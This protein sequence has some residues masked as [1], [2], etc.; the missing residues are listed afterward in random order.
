MIRLII[1][2]LLIFLVITSFVLFNPFKKAAPAGLQVA[3]NN[4]PSSIFLNDQLLNKTPLIE[5]TLKPGRYTI[6]I[7]PDDEMYVP[8]ETSIE[9]RSGALTV[10]AWRPG[11]RPE[12]SGGVIYEFEPIETKHTSEVSFVSIPDTAIVELEGERK[13]YTPV[14]FK[15]VAPGNIEYTVMLPSYVPQ[16]NTIYV[17]P[18]Q[19]MLINVK[20]AK[21]SEEVQPETANQNTDLVATSS[22]EVSENSGS[23]TSIATTSASTASD[24]SRVKILSTNFYVEGK[25]VLRARRESN[26][27]SPEVGYVAVGSEYPHTGKRE[28]GWLEIQFNETLG[29]VSGQFAQIIQ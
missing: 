4:I 27:N 14:I 20:L 28:N 23:K 5:K 6:K 8:Y 1:G 12:T 24:S 21:I 19:R 7:V 22:A 11:T 16:K 25:E 3:T 15:N 10:M 18:G 2:I 26:S 9:L 29:W 17:L 13:D